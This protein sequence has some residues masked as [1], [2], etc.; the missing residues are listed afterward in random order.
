MQI[1]I[2][3]VC[4]ENSPAGLTWSATSFATVVLRLFDLN[5]SLSN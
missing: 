1:K 3:S 5:N 4:P 2:I